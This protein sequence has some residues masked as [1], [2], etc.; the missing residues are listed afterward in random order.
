M[1]EIV[2]IVGR[3]VFRRVGDYAPKEDYFDS[4][5]DSAGA[6]PPGTVVLEQALHFSS[7]L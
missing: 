5:T 2:E 3:G 1:P 6:E 7:A 4:R